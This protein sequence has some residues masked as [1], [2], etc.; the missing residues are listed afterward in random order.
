MVFACHYGELKNGL[1]GHYGLTSVGLLLAI[2]I[3]AYYIKNNWYIYK[4]EPNKS[5]TNKNDFRH[6][7]VK[8]IQFK[9]FDS[10]LECH[11]LSWVHIN[12]Y[13][14]ESIGILRYYA[15]LTNEFFN[16]RNAL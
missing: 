4:L 5:E 6:L 9:R 14:R 10:R 7:Y 11:I 12:N 13:T 3:F 15:A 2:N 8:S 1:E 16:P